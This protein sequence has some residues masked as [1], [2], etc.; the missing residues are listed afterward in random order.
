R[1]RA[2]G[3]SRAR[4]TTRSGRSESRRPSRCSAASAHPRRRETRGRGPAGSHADE[5]PIDR[6]APVVAQA[7]DGA[8]SARLAA[9]RAPGDRS[10]SPSHGRLNVDSS[11][12]R[13]H[14]STVHTGRA[15]DHTC[16]VEIGPRY[17]LSQLF[18]TRVL[19]SQIWSA[20]TTYR[21]HAT[22]GSWRPRLSLA[23][24]ELLGR[25]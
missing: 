5:R 25:R 15:T 1:P 9:R 22:C 18:G 13:S 21:P 12:A 19:T 16:A 8:D 3:T 23:A 20:A 6:A 4:P 14:H 7:G 17:R 11:A 24:L 2:P 10:G